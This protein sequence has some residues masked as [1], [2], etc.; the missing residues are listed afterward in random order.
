MTSLSQTTER[1]E[2]ESLAFSRFVYCVQLH[3]L[4]DGWVI[5][6]PKALEDLLLVSWR[7]LANLLRLSKL[8][9]LVILES[10]SRCIPMLLVLN[11][12]SDSLLLEDRGKERAHLLR[13]DVKLLRGPRIL[14]EE[15]A[16]H[17]ILV[18]HR[19]VYLHVVNHNVVGSQL[20]ARL[21]L[22]LKVHYILRLH[23]LPLLQERC[24][25][26]KFVHVPVILPRPDSVHELLCFLES[27]R[28]RFW[29]E[30]YPF[31]NRVIQFDESLRISRLLDDLELVVRFNHRIHDH[32][33]YCL[34]HLVGVDAP[35]QRSSRLEDFVHVSY[36]ARLETDCVV[37][38]SHKRHHSAEVAACFHATVE[39][40]PRE[41]VELVDVDRI[42]PVCYDLP[43]ELLLIPVL[44]V[45][46][47]VAVAA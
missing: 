33:L 45:L 7:R 30:L 16:V 28:V 22:V 46:G 41:V 44:E 4:P 31:Q 36:L 2:N 1:N 27:W 39:A 8:L 23:L 35:V 43:Q 24:F 19:P 17:R 42:P 38:D 13:V 26:D 40:V 47:L 9:S 25:H 11:E 15:H 34:G 12:K 21:G 32:V 37:Y 3:L 5:Q 29:C 14:K 18:L 10:Q 20:N 6:L